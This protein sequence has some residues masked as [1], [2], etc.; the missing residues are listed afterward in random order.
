MMCKD[1]KE[2]VYKIATDRAQGIGT[3]PWKIFLYLLSWVYRL[4]LQIRL[5]L[6]QFRI[7]K[8]TALTKPVISVGNITLGGSGKT[9]LVE[10]LVQTL[11]ERRLSPVILMRGYMNDSSGLS[12]EATMLQDAFNDVPVI[13]QKDRLKGIKQIHQNYR[14]D[15]FILDDGF[16]H[17]K[18]RRD[19]DIVIIDATEPWGNG[20]LLPRGILREDFSSLSRAHIIVLTKSDWG[21]DNIPAIRDRLKFLPVNTLVVEARHQSVKLVSLIDS[22]EQPLTFLK[23]KSICSLASIGNPDSFRRS[24]KDLEANIM[25]GFNFIDHYAYQREDIQ[26]IISVCGEEKIDTVITT[27]KDAVKLRA[28]KGIF[29]GKSIGVYSLKIQIQVNSKKKEEEFRERILD[30]FNR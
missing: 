24:L 30:L 22:Q 4:C 11:K 5:L 15:V 7:L 10:W 26:K 12:D 14:P 8:S 19:L 21:Q 18:I 16:Q 27:H 25:A 17:W 2:F 6:Y 13:A 20:H 28:F 23:H 9:P 29:K 3:I 1:L